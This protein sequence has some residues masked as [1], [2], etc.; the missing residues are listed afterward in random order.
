M[1]YKEG[2]GQGNHTLLTILVEESAQQ[3]PD[4]AVFEVWNE[5]AVGVQ[6]RFKVGDTCTVSYNN[7]TREYNGKFY[8]SL[9]AWKVGFTA[10]EVAQQG[11]EAQPQRVEPAQ[12]YSNNVPWQEAQGGA[13][14]N[15]LPF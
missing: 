4:S 14:D 13:K 11:S 10:P 3:Y 1:D 8:N 12:Q 2:V 7:K 9:K 6:Q 5:T 15:D